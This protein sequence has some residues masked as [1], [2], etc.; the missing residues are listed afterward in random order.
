MI[1][2]D[3]NDGA[4]VTCNCIGYVRKTVSHIGL[5]ILDYSLISIGHEGHM[6]DLE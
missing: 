4:Q 5:F 6:T 1:E 3:F 2:S